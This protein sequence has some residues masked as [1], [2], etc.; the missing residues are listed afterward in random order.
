MKNL[1]LGFFLSLGVVSGFSQELQNMYKTGK[2]KLVA[3]KN[4]GQ[5]NDWNTVFRSYYDS[6][7]GNHI[8]S[9]KSLLVLPDGS[10]IVNHANQKYHSIFSPS[11]A[12]SKEIIVENSSNRPF[13]GVLSGDKMFTTI[14]NMGKL[15]VTDLNGKLIKTLHLD[16]MSRQVVAL[17]DDKLAVSGAAI[18]T[19]KFRSFVSIVD[20]QTNEEKIIWEHF[21]DRPEV[22]AG[23]NKK[24]MPF[25]YYVRLKNGLLYSFSSMPYSSFTGKGLPV[26]ITSL[27]EKLLLANPNTGELILFDADGNQLMKEKVSWANKSISVEDQKVIQS[28]A[29]EEYKALL[30]GNDTQIEL[31]QKEYEQLISDMEHDL[32]NITKPIFKPYFSTIIKDSE[33][34]ILIFEIPEEEHANQFHVWVLTNE[35]NFTSSC[36]FMADDYNLSISASKMVFHEGH[37]Y[38]LQILKNAEG[39]P[40]RLVKFKLEAD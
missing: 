30:R 7:Q 26:E 16:Y 33:D 22:V 39:N 21:T 40:L 36:T 29:I 25:N 6:I 35:G 2:V 1:I 10:V 20:Y 11:G 28:K 12:F 15:F 19:K 8:G 14:D 5:G 24:S 23:N 3:D 18:W 4:Y 38:G 32:N 9:R 37:I 13:L 31:N 17:G 34:N 27:K